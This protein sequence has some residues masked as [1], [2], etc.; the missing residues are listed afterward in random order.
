[1]ILEVEDDS[2][3]QGS[4]VIDNS[5]F[6]IE[7]MLGHFLMFIDR[8]G[9]IFKDRYFKVISR[10]ELLKS[11]NNDEEALEQ[12]IEELKEQK[13][14]IIINEQDATIT[15]IGTIA[16]LID[17]GEPGSISIGINSNDGKMADLLYPRGLTI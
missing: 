2:E 16:S 4:E 5:A 11:V 13:L 17:I 3:S 1:V 12:K 7:G 6:D 14:L 9:K 10:E 8:E 15:D